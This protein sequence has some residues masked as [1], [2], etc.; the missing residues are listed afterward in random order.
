MRGGQCSWMPQYRIP[1]LLRR[2]RQ[3]FG[4]ITTY[5][6]TRSGRTSLE[7]AALSDQRQKLDA[8]RPN[9]RC[10]AIPFST[11]G[12]AGPAD[13]G[14]L[15]LRIEPK[16]PRQRY[17]PGPYLV[18]DELEPCAGA[19]KLSLQVIALVNGTRDRI[20]VDRTDGLELRRSHRLCLARV[21]LTPGDVFGSGPYLHARR[22]LRPGIIPGLAAR[23]RR[24]HPPG[25]AGRG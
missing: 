13:A 16:E 21:T 11:T 10:P 1:A 19:G 2:N 14:G 25:Q 5:H 6:R 23:R 4:T 15:Q 9:G 20:R 12:H 22:A 8:S 7:V 24:G 18:T 3:R 17:H